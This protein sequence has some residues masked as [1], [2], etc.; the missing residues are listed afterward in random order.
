MAKD[1]GVPRSRPDRHNTKTASP[2]PYLSMSR[3]PTGTMYNPSRTKHLLGAAPS[4]H[5]PSLNPK[6]ETL[7]PKTETRNPNTKPP[8]FC[9]A[10]NRNLRCVYTKALCKHR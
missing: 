8:R 3:S 9:T 10:L 1:A 4:D 7:N 5:N 6:P 2:K